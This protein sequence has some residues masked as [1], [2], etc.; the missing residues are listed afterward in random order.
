[1]NSLSLFENQLPL[2]DIGCLD[3]GL[4]AQNRAWICSEGIGIVEPKWDLP[5]DAALRGRAPH[6]RALTA[7]P[8]LPDYFPGYD[9]YIWIDCDAWVREQFVLEW[10]SRTAAS[11]ALSIV[12]ELDRSYDKTLTSAWRA[13]R[14]RRYYG[15]NA[16]QQIGARN[17]YNAGV[18]ALRGDAPHWSHW[19]E[20]FAHGLDA[21]AG[22]VVCDQTALN[23]AIG[24]RSLPVHPLPSICNWLC[25]LALPHID[26]G[27]RKFCE[28]Y[29]PHAT[30]GILHLAANTKDLTFRLHNENGASD[31]IS[32]RFRAPQAQENVSEP[33]Q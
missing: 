2:A 12:P 6:L 21:T 29:F 10:L 22:T 20:S 33:V 9:V 26:P 18:F 11:G 30:I 27:T 8:F 5:V 15:D 28:P 7:R 16:A 31:E 25:H 17:Y 4:N 3:V 23:H 32:L 14:L 13:D 19:A 1:M 24:S